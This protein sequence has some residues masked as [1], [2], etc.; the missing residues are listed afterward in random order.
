MSEGCKSLEKIYLGAFYKILTMPF[1][2]ASLENFPHLREILVR[3]LFAPAQ[4]APVEDA[5]SAPGT[6]ASSPA[7]TRYSVRST[8][9]ERY[10]LLPSVDKVLILSFLCSQAVSSK[11]IHAHME[12][13]E[14]QLTE[15]RKQKIE[16]NR[17]KK[18]LY[19]TRPISIS[20]RS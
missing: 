13:C 5:P 6:P 7:P 16:V 15:L 4:E 1:Q 3:L 14:E 11:A 19:V 8:P 18:Q 2:H 17:A 9:K 12:S 20:V 10:P